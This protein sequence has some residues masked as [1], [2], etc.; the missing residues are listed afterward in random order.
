MVAGS[1]NCRTFCLPKSSDMGGGN[2]SIPLELMGA[3]RA[4]IFSDGDRARGFNLIALTSAGGG[5]MLAGSV[6]RPCFCL[7]TISD[8]GG[9]KISVSDF[10]QAERFELIGPISVGGGRI[11]ELAGLGGSSTFRS[12]KTL[13]LPARTM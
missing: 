10:D 7:S 1:A 13:L 6:N 11:A 3:E 8:M 5:G 9:G 2:I 4:V 12:T